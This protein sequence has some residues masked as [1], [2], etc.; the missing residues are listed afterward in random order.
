MKRLLAIAVVLLLPAGRAGA[1]DLSGRALLSFQ[2]Y[3]LGRVQTA[4]LRQTYDLQ[5]QH[6]FTTTS[7]VR[8][9][10]RAD[11]FAGTTETPLLSENNRS[12]Q[13]QPIGEFLLNAETLRIQ[14][15]SEMLDTET[16]GRTFESTQTVKRS[17][18]RLEWR[19]FNLPRFEIRGQRNEIDNQSAG[20]TLTEDF[21]NGAVSYEWRGLSA[22]V[23]ER[24]DRAVDPN[25]GYDRKNTSHLGELSFTSTA[26]GGRFSIGALGSVRLANIDERATSGRPTSVPVP[27]PLTRASYSIDDTPADGRDHPLSPLPALTDGNL[28]RGAGLSLGPDS[29]SFQNLAFDLGR[30]DRVDEIRIVVRDAA[31]NPVRNGGGPVTWDLYVS[32]DGNLWTPIFSETAWN[33]PLSYYGVTFELSTA[34]WFK[35]VNFG[36]NVEA[37]LV[38]EVQA[39]YHRDLG[40][41]GRRSGTQNQYNATAT[42]SLQPTR[43]LSLGYTGGYSALDE[44]I[45]A[46]LPIEAK[47]TEHTATVQYSFFRNFGVRTQYVRRDAE[48]FTGQT[49]SAN[50]G[51]VVLDWTP[52]RQLR[53]SLELSRDDQVL[54]ATTFTIDTRAVHVTAGVVRALQLLLDLGTQTQT[55]TSDGTTAN[56]QFANL[57]ANAQLYRSLRFTL[58]GSL[59][60]TETDSIDPAVQLLGPTRD[61]RIS[62]ELLWRPGRPLTL[63]TRVGWVSGGAL[64]GFT[65][66]FHVEW[67]PFADGS[68]SLGG[69]YDEDIDPMLD[70]RASRL[71]FNPRWIMN[72]W[73]TFDI[74]YTSVSSSYG[75]ITDEQKMLFATLTVTR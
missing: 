55:F 71:V 49:D 14:A 25:T 27:V 60:R 34:R 3:D 39:Y 41:E 12:R 67:Y 64:S 53:T 72:H 44:D 16:R 35:V 63:S 58:M 37:T 57:T 43:N 75:P 38:T 61:Q 13:L 29:I 40:P 47:A 33:A 48:T 56:R 74:Q 18:G 32:E 51:T 17:S 2:H 52:T 5:L 8:L 36:V 28:D 54:G 66:R 45:K 1:D 23:E 59:Q 70:R 6:A 73:A 4:G 69:S 30:S 15:R 26:L 46:F 22:R 31:G 24:Y 19:P 9:F 42:V 62:G 21:V 68:V 50:T 20:L 65:Q 10:F 7:L 11:D